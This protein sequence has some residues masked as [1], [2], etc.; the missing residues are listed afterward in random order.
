[1]RA[2]IALVLGLMGAALCLLWPTPAGA[3][4]DG[5]SVV[6]Q[7]YDSDLQVQQGGDVAVRETIQIAFQGGPFTQG[8]R[9]ISLS[10]L[11]GVTGVS[12][13]QTS[14]EAVTFRPGQGQ[15]Y[16][17]AVTG[18]ASGG[19]LEIRW[20]FPPTTNSARTFVV[21]YTAQGAVRYYEGGD[22]LYWDVTNSAPY[23]IQSST[24]TLRL[25]PGVSV[26]PNQWVTDFTPRRFLRSS[27]V[28]ADGTVTWQAGGI[29][30]EEVFEVRA[31]WPHGLVSGSPP[32]WQQAAD[33]QDRLEQTLAP[34]FTFFAALAALV[35]ALGGGLWLLITWYVRGRDPAVGSVP[36]ELDSPPSELA[37]ALVGTVVDEHADSQDVVA[38]VLDLAARGEIAIRETQGKAGGRPD[39]ELELRHDRATVDPTLRPFERIVLD[40][41]FTRGPKVNLS[42][43]GG[44]WQYAVPRIETALHEEA[45]AAGLFYDDPERTRQRYRR[46]GTLVALAGLVLGAGSCALAPWYATP[47]VWPFLCL[48]GVGLALRFLAGRMPRRTAAGAIEAARWRAYGRHLLRQPVA[49]LALPG[50]AQNDPGGQNGGPVATTA[51]ED[52]LARAQGRAFERTL[53]YAVALGLARPWVDKFAAAGTAAPQWLAPP[54]VVAGGPGWGSPYGPYGCL[55]YTSPS[56]RD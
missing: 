18:G 44:W 11:E 28:G 46:W 51:S 3:Q 10:R 32:A 26:P 4:S 54:V 50:G 55:L 8:F 30:A 53:P 40:S 21:G 27:G 34:A 20:W 41:F 25:P 5:R 19:D 2:S 6:A 49:Q 37:P 47:V 1:M 22:Q 35:V 48:A 52:V 36:Q 9:T 39:F 15:P 23:A 56:P 33:A 42:E 29:P 17:F 24:T 14:P 16:T 38:T 7:R 13:Q 12:V 31:Q 43:L 45:R